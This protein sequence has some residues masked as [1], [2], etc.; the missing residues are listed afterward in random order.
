MER[1]LLLALC[2]LLAACEAPPRAFAGKITTPSQLV[3]GPRSLGQTGDYR[4]SNGRVRFVVQGLDLTPGSPGD[5]AFGAFGGALLDA[6]LAR[7]EEERDPRTQ[8]NGKDGLGEI[9]PTFFLRGLEPSGIEVLNDGAD[10]RAAH[11]R[12]TGKGSDFFTATKLV[13]GLLPAQVQYQLDYRLGPGDDALWL[14]ASILNPTAS[15]VPFA[16]KAQ[17]PLA[18]GFIG[19]FGDGQP[20]FLPGEAGFDVRFSLQR[21]YG[22]SYQLPALGGVTSDVIAVTGEGISYGLSYCNSTLCPAPPGL[23][24][25]GGAPSFVFG[26]ADQ[27]GQYAPVTE[28]S[29]LLPFV[30]GSLF[31]FYLEEVPDQLP[32]GK[33]VSATLKLRVSG[34]SPSAVIDAQMAEAGVETGAVTGVVRERLTGRILPGADVIFL[35]DDGTHSHAGFAVNTARADEAGRISATLPPGSYLAVTRLG[36]R[37][38]APDLAFAVRARQHVDLEAVAQAAGA[39]WTI[40]QDALLV[41]GV[42]DDAGAPIPAKVTIDAAYDARYAGMDP[43]SFLYDLRLGDP[44]R[45]TDLIP[46]TSDPE[47]RRYIEETLRAVNGHAEAEVRPGRWRVTVSRGPAWSLHAEEVTLTPGQATPVLAKLSR[48]LPA[49]GRIS[50]DQHVHT[51]GSVDGSLDFDERVKSYAAEGIDLL[52]ATDHNALSEL[53]PAIERAGL[54]DYLKSAVGIELSSLEAGH[55]NAYPLLWQPAPATHGSVPWFNKIPQQ[56]FDELRAGR[57]APLSSFVVQ[58][59]HPRDSVQGMFTTY[60]LTGDPLTGDPALDWP[61]ETGTFAPSGPGFGAGKLSL[62]FDAMEVLNNKRLDIA[63]TFRVPSDAALAGYAACELPPK[64]G[65]VLYCDGK[66]VA[67][68]P[69]RGSPGTIVRDASDRVAFPGAFEDWE[70]LLDAGKRLTAV[71]NSDSHGLFEEAGV[72]HNLIDLGHD[73]ASARQLDPQEAARA[74]KAGRVVVTNGPQLTLTLLD[75]VAKAA[76]GAPLEVPIGGL[77]RA[78][79]SGGRPKAQYH[80]VVEAA[81]WIDVSRAALLVGGPDCQTDDPKRSVSDCHEKPVAIDRG[82]PGQRPVLRLDVKGSLDLPAGR[83]T[84]VAA[85]VTGETSLWPVVTPLEV[86]PLLLN[87]AIGTLTAAFGLSDPLKKLRPATITQAL[88]IAISN[89]VL[90]DGDGDGKWWGSPVPAWVPQAP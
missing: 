30:S 29:M 57:A 41:V 46:D 13:N 71:G 40:P 27:Y 9:F 5:R 86:P 44:Y 78:D 23:D 61:G 74:I 22:R 84:W 10:G 90:I 80:L 65:A 36:R 50:S 81:P 79:T 33:A 70:H 7:P 76:D 16:A 47:T 87:D 49:R 54:A 64:C 28:Q 26:H 42:T 89:P 75:P 34:A 2:A 67:D 58:V 3:G 25:L 14:T 45:P 4:L 55:V 24:A 1:R 85:Y 8:G 18:I 31:G 48:L 37:E 32:P 66:A 38:H 73:L 83:D 53:G 11:L 52:V 69:C 62:D 12:V 17:F 39:D 35:Q 72:P 51:K 19:L 63:R 43:K 88:P 20:L 68:K 6:D 82:T 21:A 60:G 15:P 77:V 56:L 59:N